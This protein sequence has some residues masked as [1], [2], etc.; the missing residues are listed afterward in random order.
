MKTASE[1]LGFTVVDRI[2][3][4]KGV[5][6]GAVY[7]LTGCNQVL[8]QP[9]GLN[10]KDGVKEPTWF[11]VQRVVEVLSVPRCVLENESTPGFDKPAPKR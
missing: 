8:V 5:V 2:T 1:L 7:Y 10:E 3:G 11:D 6:T 4:Y 9:S